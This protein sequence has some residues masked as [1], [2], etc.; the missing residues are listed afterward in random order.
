MGVQGGISAG[1]F[2]LAVSF[3]AFVAGALM[4]VAEMAPAGYVRDAYRAGLALV[5]KRELQATPYATDLWQPA[6]TER[7][8][9]QL[10]DPERS[11]PGLT[12]FTSGHAPAAYLIEPDGSVA[13][14]WH[15]SYSRLH[16]E[17]AAVADPLP[18]RQVY[19]R[20]AHLYPNGDLL[21]LYVG[22]GDSPWGYGLARLDRSSE[23]VWKNLDRFHHDLSVAED[24]R[25]V[26]LTHAYREDVPEGLDHLSRP[27]LDDYLTVVGPD[28][29]TQ[30]KFS[31]LETLER[32]A[33]RDL[34]WQTPT[35]TLADP[36]H[37]NAVDVLSQRDASRL[38][39]KIPAAAPGQVLVSFREVGGGLIALVDPV[40]EELLWAQRGQWRSQ[41]DPDV[42]P[43]GNLLLF[44][45]LGD[46]GAAGRSRVVEIDP[47]HGGVVWAYGG[48]E[49]KP[50]ESVIRSA[51]QPLA[52][53]NV[54]ITESD[55]GRLLEITREGEP[56]WEYVNPVRGGEGDEFIPIVSWAQR[57]DPAQLD[58]AFRTAL[59]HDHLAYQGGLP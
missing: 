48:S 55:G 32:S 28:G 41:H 33:Y 43:N 16:D 17:S 6:R 14:H 54:L 21:A 23:V 52:N 9:L 37:T 34:L 51:Q 39:Q 26:T 27:V 13:H 1:A 15:A 22:V 46:Y 44:D 8:G 31:L 59:L 38:A 36:L 10:H 50:L 25:I 40:E 29:R 53:G 12:L 57:V 56:V 35:Y 47:A 49:D 42:L 45:N 5:H 19:F 4:A 20:R 3:L 11:A 7:R 30:H 18:D 58:T 24:G 2:V